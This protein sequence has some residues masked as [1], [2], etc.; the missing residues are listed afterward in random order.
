MTAYS[1]P[2]GIA[3]RYPVGTSVQIC[4]AHQAHLG[5][6]PAG[7]PIATATVGADGMSIDGL[8]AGCWYV[9]Y[10]PVGQEHR[11]V[12]FRMPA[13]RPRPRA[14]VND[15]QIATSGKVVGVPWSERVAARQRLQRAGR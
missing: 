9:A 15:V 4:E 6:A 2:P 8:R 10:A 3:E 11:Y 12:R 5:A 13:E 1:F 14:G 7:A